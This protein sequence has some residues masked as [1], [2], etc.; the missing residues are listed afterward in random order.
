MKDRISTSYKSGSGDSGYSV[1]L[2]GHKILKS[3]PACWIYA[4]V[5]KAINTVSRILIKHPIEYEYLKNLLCFLQENLFSLSSFCFCKGQTEKFAVNPD[6]IAALNTQ[7]KDIQFVVGNAA[8][9]IWY[10]EEKSVD[11]DGLRILIR[12]TERAFTAWRFHPTVLE[13]I[14]E[15][16]SH[17]PL[18][19]Q[20]I[21]NNIKLY[22]S[23]LNRLSNFLWW[24]IRYENIQANR[25]N[26]E[27]YWTGKLEITTDVVNPNSSKIKQVKKELLENFP[28][29]LYSVKN[30]IDTFELDKHTRIVINNNTNE[31]DIDSTSSSAK[32]AWMK[33]FNLL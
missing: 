31:I 18:T 9:F 22:A 20:T 12:D 3:D 13:H 7:I 23:L 6:L 25:Q 11:L 1:L 2:D 32:V 15:V 24:A 16:V 5:E 17:S 30:N 4:E 21:V 14:V 27:N 8:D 29:L 19:A 10:S 28:K 26:P 33:H